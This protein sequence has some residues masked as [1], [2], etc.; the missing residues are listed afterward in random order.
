MHVCKDFKLIDFFASCFTDI[1]E[2][3]LGTDLCDHNCR[4]VNGS[5]DCTC[6]PGYRLN[7]DGQTC[8]GKYVVV[9]P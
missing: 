2:C 5:Y 7:T 6:N 1:N 3:A 8:A 4:N 9:E